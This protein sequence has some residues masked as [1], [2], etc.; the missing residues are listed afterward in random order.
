M[1]FPHMSP[2]DS[3]V[4][5]RFLVLHPL[6]FTEL[7]YDVHVGTGQIAWN[8]PKANPASEWL[9]IAAKRIDV[10]ALHDGRPAIVEVKP[11][12]SMSAIGQ[13]LSYRDLLTHAEKP[14]TPY[15]CWV[16]CASRDADLG[17]TYLR[18]GIGVI[19]VGF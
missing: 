16:V 3:I 18:Y 7:R 8:G 11:R 9:A 6:M 1:K 2:E 12:A 17:P 5:R 19:A 4:W 14:S 10:V 13:V 15:E